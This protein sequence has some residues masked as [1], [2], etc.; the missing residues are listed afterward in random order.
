MHRVWISNTS[1]TPVIT[2]WYTSTQVNVVIPRCVPVLSLTSHL[3]RKSTSSFFFFFHEECIRFTRNLPRNRKEWRFTHW[4]S[5][6]TNLF[7]MGVIKICITSDSK[8][9]LGQTLNLA[10]VWNVWMCNR[11]YFARADILTKECWFTDVGSECLCEFTLYHGWCV[12]EC[13]WVC[14]CEQA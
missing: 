10:N 8:R 13:V 3:P 12:C 11:V 14:V 9:V 1:S 5:D 2:V 7:V 6:Y 4:R